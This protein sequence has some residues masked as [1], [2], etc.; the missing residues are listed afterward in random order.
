MNEGKY[1]IYRKTG[2]VIKHMFLTEQHTFHPDVEKA[3]L[4][5]KLIA[6]DIQ[7]SLIAFGSECFTIKKRDVFILEIMES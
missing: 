7:A 2:P 4:L 3:Q 6:E 1:I 5:D